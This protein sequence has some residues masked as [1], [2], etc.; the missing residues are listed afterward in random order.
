MK[1]AVSVKVHDKWVHLDSLPEKDREE[2][3]KKIAEI[4]TGALKQQ[5][6][7]YISGCCSNGSKQDM[8]AMH[9]GRAV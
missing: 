7:L 6:N 8:A 2:I 1:P 9:R 4:L 5:I 3:R